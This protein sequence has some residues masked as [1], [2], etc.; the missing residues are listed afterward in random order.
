MKTQA[1]DDRSHA[2]RERGGTGTGKRVELHTQGFFLIP[3]ED[4]V[5]K[6]GIYGRQEVV[7]SGEIFAF[8]RNIGCSPKMPRG[9]I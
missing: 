1:H 8:E 5:V 6:T 2:E 4:D 9:V 7:V 3:A